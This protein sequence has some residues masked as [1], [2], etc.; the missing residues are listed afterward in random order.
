[1]THEEQ[2]VQWVEGN[3]MHDVE[4]NRCCPD[5]SCCRPTLKE[6]ILIRKLYYDAFLEKNYEL[7][8][9]LL[10]MFFNMAMTQNTTVTEELDV[11]TVR[12]SIPLGKCIHNK[13]NNANS[14]T[15]ILRGIRNK[16]FKYPYAIS[17]T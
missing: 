5:F 13:D 10:I 11:K 3:S 1:M 17:C 8:D 14:E 16:H 6:D 15:P 12:E 2:L 7:Q 4:N 9:T